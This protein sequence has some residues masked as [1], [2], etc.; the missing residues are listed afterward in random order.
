MNGVDDAL[1]IA[2]LVAPPPFNLN[3]VGESAARPARSGLGGSVSL[4]ESRLQRTVPGDDPR[5]VGVAGSL[6]GHA[7]DA[8][9][10]P[11]EQ[12]RQEPP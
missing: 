8:S 3:A 11:R 6:V 2:P 5:G 4:H 7:R 1:E 10:R 9:S 12:S